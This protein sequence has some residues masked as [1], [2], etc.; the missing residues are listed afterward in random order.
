[1]ECIEDIWA[2]NMHVPLSL[3]HRFYI[4]KNRLFEN[5]LVTAN[6]SI[7]GRLYPNELI[8]YDGS[9]YINKSL[10][11]VL[12]CGG[13]T[14]GIVRNHQGKRAVID[15]TNSDRYIMLDS[16]RYD[17]LR[18]IVDNDTH[19]LFW[20]CDTRTVH[21]NGKGHLSPVIRSR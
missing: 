1:M 3:V 9:S 19:I 13:D 7:D 8:L 6:L 18:A 15:V 20:D 2:R 4:E 10:F 21:V 11:E 5:N 16:A 12:Q 14:D 17:L